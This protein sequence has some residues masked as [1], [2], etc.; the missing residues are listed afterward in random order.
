[1]GQTFPEH[2]ADITEFARSA[3]L[4]DELRGELVFLPEVVV[5]THSPAVGLVLPLWIEVG[6]GKGDVPLTVHYGQV[7]ARLLNPAIE[8]LPVGWLVQRG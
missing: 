8:R 3:D 1:M 6:H 2:W 5:M 7:V 4:G